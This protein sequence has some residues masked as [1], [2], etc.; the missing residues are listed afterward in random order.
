MRFEQTLPAPR[1]RVAGRNHGHGA[2]P[3]DPEVGIVVGHTDIF[4]RIVR[5]VDSVADVRNRGKR[6]EPVQEAWRDIKMSKVVIVKQKCLLFA[7][8]GGIPAD[9]YK[10]V[11]HGPMGAADEL[12]LAAARPPVHTPHDTHHRT[13][14]R[15]LYERG[16]RARCARI[17][18]ENRRVECSGEQ[19]P[20]IARRLRCKNHNVGEVS[21]LDSHGIM[22]P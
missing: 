18:I 7:E 9:V 17:A 19:S 1:L 14:L 10:D 20:V 16:G 11:V 5:T 22:L 3:R 12:R 21:L 8:G 6:L 13:R 15:V 4:A 2:R